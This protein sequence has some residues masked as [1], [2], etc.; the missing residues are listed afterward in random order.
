MTDS[1]RPPST[2]GY[3]SPEWHHSRAVLRYLVNDTVA[4]PDAA[5]VVLDTLVRKSRMV[6]GYPVNTEVDGYDD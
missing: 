5:Q 1:G 4:D 6:R 2:A 3:P